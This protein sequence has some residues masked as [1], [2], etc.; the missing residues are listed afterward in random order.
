MNNTIQIDDFD[1]FAKDLQEMGFLVSGKKADSLFVNYLGTKLVVRKKDSA[2][3]V[4]LK[5][6]WLLLVLLFVIVL[7]IVIIGEVTGESDLFAQNGIT[8][9][10]IASFIS[11]VLFFLVILAIR[12]LAKKKYVKQ[13]CERIY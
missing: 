8:V 7:A 6:P 2:C 13:F 10:V 11:A 12:Y 1:Q 5:T 3:K 4:G 9:T